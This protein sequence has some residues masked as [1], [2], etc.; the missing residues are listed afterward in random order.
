M[1]RIKRNYQC[2]PLPDTF[3]KEVIERVW[4]KK[5]EAFEDKKRIAKG[6][7]VVV[8]PQ[9]TLAVH[10]DRCG[11]GTHEGGVWCRGYRPRHGCAAE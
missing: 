10:R 11:V 2:F 4:N 9:G 7:Y 8:F 3:E 1:A 5:S 6:G